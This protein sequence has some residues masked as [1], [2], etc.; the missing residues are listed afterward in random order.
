MVIDQSGRVEETNKITI[1][2]LADKKKS[3]A[4]ALSPKTKKELQA[5]FRKLGKPKTFPVVIF[6][7]TVFM[8]MLRS[9]NF[10]QELIIDSEYPGHENTIKNIIITL[11]RRFKKKVP[12]IY[13]SNIGKKDPAHLAAW[14][15]YTKKAKPN[16]ILETENF[17]GII[18]K[19]KI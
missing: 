18:P 16:I 2:A 6:A 5:I 19:K 3:F 11:C 4:I 9:R 17:K 14:N 12:D 8:C 7:D 10:P 1:V 15:V 13:F